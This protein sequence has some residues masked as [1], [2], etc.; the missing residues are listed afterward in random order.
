LKDAKDTVFESETARLYGL[1]A[2][3]IES[4][5]RGLRGKAKAV[6]VRAAIAVFTHVGRMRELELLERIERL[7]QILEV[8][9]C[10]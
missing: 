4:L 9:K 3:A 7:E 5:K 8:R 1:A 6:E 2:M 10:S